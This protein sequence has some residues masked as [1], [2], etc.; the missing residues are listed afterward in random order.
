[1]P[2]VVTVAITSDNQQT[3]FHTEC[4]STC[5]EALSLYLGS[6]VGRRPGI[7][8]AVL[9]AIQKARYLPFTSRRVAFEGGVGATHCTRVKCRALSLEH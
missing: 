5:L 2:T 7:V 8:I 3:T 9:G 1:M 6:W 4:L